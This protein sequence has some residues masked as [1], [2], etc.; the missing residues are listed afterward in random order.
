MKLLFIYD[1]RMFFDSEGNWY[2]RDFAAL[3]EKYR[4]LADDITFM[5][6]TKPLSDRSGY[7]KMPEGIHVVEIP[8]LA[9]PN[10]YI[11]EKRNAAK[12]V[13]EQI[14]KC[15]MAI[16]R[17]PCFYSALAQKYL[18]KY[19]KP[20]IV[21]SVGCPWDSYRNHG[22]LG[23][24]LAPYEFLQTRRS[25]RSAPYV[26]YVT[27]EFLQR[28]YPTKGLAAGISDAELQCVDDS[29]LEKRLAHI[30]SHS[31]ALKIG[32]AG[33]IDVPYKGQQYVIEALAKLKQQGNTGFE[34]HLAGGNDRT[35][36]LTLAEKLGV[37]DQV[38]FEG[39]L[40]HDRLF[41]WL[42]ELDVYIQ[43]SLQEGL[44]RAVVEAMSRG[45]P[46]F[47]AKTGGIPELVGQSCIFPQKD[48]G[49]IAA[50]LSSVTVEDMER[51]A[52][53]NFARAADFEYGTLEARRREFYQRFLNDFK[54][55]CK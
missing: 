37:G 30:R 14:R 29:V 54:E 35:V 46:V 1:G 45:L 27:G 26:I 36:L 21:E 17:E 5:M 13:A 47:G 40:P 18:K 4:V 44:P 52:R 53:E 22:T 28:R 15:D 8:N 24:L 43:P 41:D 7:M 12:I 3:P 42:D 48:S 50:L 11:R 38:I 33:A 16:L 9:K 34:Y 20:Y 2:S 55:K 49:S 32:T 51:S 31:G 19:T 6:R 39:N 25:I 23:K 10:V